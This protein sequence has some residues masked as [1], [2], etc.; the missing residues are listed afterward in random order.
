[1]AI[2]DDIVHRIGR[3]A[4][5]DARAML[6]PALLALAGGVTCVAGLGFLAAS[7]YLALDAVLGPGLAALLTG[8]GLT[9]LSLGLVMLARRQMAYP[10]PADPAGKTPA[11]QDKAASDT[12]SQ[13]AFTTA[14]VLARYLGGDRRG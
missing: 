7:A 6:V 5:K 2:V 8:A 4:R 1:M 10:G 13:I 14:F 3:D 9:L 12:A 11:E